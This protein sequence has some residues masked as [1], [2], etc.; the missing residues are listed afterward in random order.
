MK[1][2]L[3]LKILPMSVCQLLIS[4]GMINAMTKYFKYAQI[5]LQRFLNSITENKD[6]RAVL[7]YC[8]GDYGK[9]SFFLKGRVSSGLEGTSAMK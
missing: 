5:P 8:F 2:A 7:S 9:Y 4:T 3:L 1:T 6:L